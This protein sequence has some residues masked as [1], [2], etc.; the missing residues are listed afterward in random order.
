M[1]LVSFLFQG[2]VREGGV[3]MVDV[4]MWKWAV[5]GFDKANERQYFVA[6]G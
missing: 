3:Y 1:F 2:G 5:D 4:K 6:Q